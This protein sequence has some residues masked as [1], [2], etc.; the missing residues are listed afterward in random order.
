MLGPKE[1]ADYRNSVESMSPE[2]KKEFFDII[3]KDNKFDSMDDWFKSLPVYEQEI[4]ND[5]Y[6]LYQ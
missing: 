6:H 4:I 5:T 2:E 1:I 3:Y